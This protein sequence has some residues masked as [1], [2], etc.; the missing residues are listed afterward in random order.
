MMIVMVM[1]IFYPF[2]SLCKNL[3]HFIASFC[4]R[5][6]GYSINEWLTSVF[7]TLLWLF[8]VKEVV[9]LGDCVD[10]VS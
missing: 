3:I 7:I 4:L 9:L 1:M 8:V 6:V 10:C 2:E 5:F